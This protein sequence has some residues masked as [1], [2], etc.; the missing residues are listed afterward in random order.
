ML[1]TSISISLV[2][3]RSSRIPD[4]EGLGGP[5]RVR[6]RSVVRPRR[7]S[8]PACQWAGAASTRTPRVA[9]YPGHLGRP[10]VLSISSGTRSVLQSARHRREAAAAS[11]V[12]VFATVTVTACQGAWVLVRARGCVPVVTGPV[13]LLAGNRLS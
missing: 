10:G 7:I 9:S 1:N 3:T 6:P 5:S 8:P 12:T 4:K 11:G 2:E 13:R